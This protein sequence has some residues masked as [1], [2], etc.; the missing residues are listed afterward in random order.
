MVKVGKSIYIILYYIIICFNFINSHFTLFIFKIIEDCGYTNK[1]IQQIAL[2]CNQRKDAAK[3]AQDGSIILHLVNYLEKLP[4]EGGALVEDA[5][6]IG[7]NKKAFDIYVPKYGLEYH[8]NLNSLPLKQSV[9]NNGRLVLQWNTGIEATHERAIE[10]YLQKKN[11][12][13]NNSNDNQCN[14]NENDDD[15]ENIEE[16]NENHNS[17]MEQLINELSTLGFNDES[18]INTPRCIHS[19]ILNKD[20]CTQVIDIL[21]KLNVSL[22][23]DKSRSPSQIHIYP[24]NP[25]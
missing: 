1:A 3:N 6:V 23:P 9:Y 20:K 7:T 10:S 18:S 15:D 8:V 24:I 12:N 5:V 25:F 2:S 16:V 14:E 22:F 21:T 13:S 11:Y 19:S 17:N 4:K